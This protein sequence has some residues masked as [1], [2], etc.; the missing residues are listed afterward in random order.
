MVTKLVLPG[1]LIAEKY[2]FKSS[3]AFAYD[4]SNGPFGVV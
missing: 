3:L 2:R 4:I 1:A